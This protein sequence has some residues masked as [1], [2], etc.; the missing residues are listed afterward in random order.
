MWAK[1]KQSGFTIVEL[2]IVIVVI[3]I[4]AAITIVAY[5]GIQ[6]RANNTTTTSVAKSFKTA[7]TAY[8]IDNGRYPVTSTACLGTGYPDINSDGLGDCGTSNGSVTYSNNV[9]MDNALK[10]YRAI[11]SPSM[12]RY[13]TNTW[14]QFG[15]TFEYLAGYI[16]DGVSNPWWMTYELGGTNEKCANSIG[17]ISMAG[18]PNLSSTPPGGWNGA[19]EQWTSAIKCWLPLPDP[20]KL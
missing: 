13:N 15:I 1:H 16:L 9:T 14:V 11:G 20:S 7:L 5:N 4:L 3:G 19:S 18:S 10:A 6:Q 12:L 8:A 2:L 17:G